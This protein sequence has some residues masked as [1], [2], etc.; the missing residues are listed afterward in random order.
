M[1]TSCCPVGEKDAKSTSQHHIYPNEARSAGGCVR[2]DPA[3]PHSPS[4]YHSARGCTLFRSGVTRSVH[5][6]VTVSPSLR[7]VTPNFS[8]NW[9]SKC[10]YGI[11]DGKGTA[12]QKGHVTAG[13]A[14]KHQ[15]GAQTAYYRALQSAR[16]MPPSG[17]PQGA[18]NAPQL[19]CRS[20][21]LTPVEG[22]RTGPLGRHRARGAGEGAPWED[23][24]PSE[25]R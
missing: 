18:Q 1:A 22:V 6:R 4:W 8:K 9:T 12:E 25:M 10:M 19:T 5:L 11:T 14:G 24:C 2:G 13:G 23:Q 17:E 3:G 7:K 20:S 16:D 15:Q 21:Y